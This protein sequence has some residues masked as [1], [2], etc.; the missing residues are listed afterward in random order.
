[1]KNS[2]LQIEAEKPKENRKRNER[3]TAQSQRGTVPPIEE[4]V[5]YR[6]TEV[7][8]YSLVSTGE[9]G[10][11]VLLCVQRHKETQLQELPQQVPR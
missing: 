5:C 8:H 9:A 3:E 1:M 10:S 2:M 6:C 4:I 11:V 7:G